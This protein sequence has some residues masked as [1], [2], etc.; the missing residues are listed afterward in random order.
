MIADGKPPKFEVLDEQHVRYTWDQPNPRFLPQLAGPRRSRH[1]SPGALPQKVPRPLRRQGE[2]GGRGARTEAE[3]LGGPSQ[4]PR[5]HEGA[6]N[7]DLPVLMPWRVTNPRA[8]NAL[9]LRAQSLLP[10]GRHGG[11][12]TSLCRPRSSWTSRPAAFSRRRPMRARSISCSAACRMGDIPVLKE[13]EKA[14]G[15]RTLL[16]PYARGIRTRA[17]SQ[18]QCDDPVWRALNRDVRY[19]RAL[20]LGIDR[21]TLN[22]ALLFGLGI[23]GNNTIMAREPAFATGAAHDECRL[24]S[25]RGLAP[26]RRDRA[27]QAQRRR[28]PPAAR[29]PRTGDHRRDRWRKLASSST[30]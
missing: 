23:E 15:Y 24:R 27:D 14:Q 20:S 16:W 19:R 1:L 7:P 5:R 8:G 12:A 22:N 18:P 11:A 26:A 10:P 21:K 28:H 29:R 2:A 30:G 17:L 6:D 25:R 13:G 4:S 3:I 9:H